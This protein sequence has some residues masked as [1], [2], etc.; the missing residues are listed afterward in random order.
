MTLAERNDVLLFGPRV[1][2]RPFTREDVDAWQVWPDY[3]DP[4]LVATSPRRMSPEQRTLW[5]EDLLNRQRQVPYAVDD[6]RGIMIGRLFLRMVR[7]DE[8]SAILGIDFHPA[9]LGQRYGTEALREFL[10]HFFEV[11]GFRR[12]LLSV[13]AFNVRALRSY[14]SLGFRRVGT[15]W[16][17]HAGPDV[18]RDPAY[19]SVHHF[20]R[21]SVMGLESLFYDMAL[22]RSTWMRRR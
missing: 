12:M 3:D 1:R 5:F 4:L 19:R 10:D 7:R 22:E 14:E 16:D 13:G 18:T 15:R 8:G 6:E 2:I 17:M 9:Y 21:R 11:L 20:F